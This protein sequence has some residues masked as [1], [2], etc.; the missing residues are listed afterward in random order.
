MH[1]STE[2]TLIFKIFDMIVCRH[3]CRYLMLNALILHVPVA[4]HVSGT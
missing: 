4:I 2:T 1:I 3:Y